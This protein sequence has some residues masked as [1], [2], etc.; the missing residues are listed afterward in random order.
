MPD[1]IQLR[2]NPVT[3]AVVPDG[4]RRYVVSELVVDE[5]PGGPATIRLV[6]EL[7][8]ARPLNLTDAAA[9][10]TAE[11]R[12]ALVRAQIEA[13]HAAAV[14]RTIRFIEQHGFEK[15]AE[16]SAIPNRHHQVAAIEELERHA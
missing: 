7:D 13:D 6:S 2:R 10:K 11:A 14:D 9:P 12:L 15:H 1:P 3:V 8:P 4:D 5:A 16:I